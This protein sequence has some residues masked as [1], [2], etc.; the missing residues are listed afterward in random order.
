MEA[1]RIRVGIIG[2]SP[3]R[4]WAARAHVPALLALPEYRITAVGT[5]RPES[6][7]AAA[8]SSGPR[9]LSPTPG[10]S[11]STLRWTWSSSP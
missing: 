9:T 4:G 11:P 3:D 7:R 10:N 5:S 8:R 2:A 6:A 1:K